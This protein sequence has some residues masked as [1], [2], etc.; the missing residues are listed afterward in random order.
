MRTKGLNRDEKQ[1]TVYSA[2]SGEIE[3]NES[4]PE[5]PLTF[6]L[7]KLIKKKVRSL[8]GGLKCN[9]Q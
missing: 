5:R 8:L 9:N 3:G 1:S 4:V 2:M 6:R 7:T